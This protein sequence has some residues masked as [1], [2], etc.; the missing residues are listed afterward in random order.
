MA[1]M[2]DESP[3]GWM[4]VVTAHGDDGEKKWITMRGGFARPEE[5]EGN[6]DA[7]NS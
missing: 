1:L 4:E 6:D 2:V 5:D 7:S 3:P